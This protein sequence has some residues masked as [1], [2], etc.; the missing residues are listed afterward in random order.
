MYRRPLCWPVRTI[1]KPN[2]LL[3][4]VFTGVWLKFVV[5]V[6][7]AAAAAI[8]A[9]TVVAAALMA[10]ANLPLAVAVLAANEPRRAT[11]WF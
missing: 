4:R 6:A 1:I 11:T 5:V 3:K 7:A 2:K 10:H 9:V 8:V